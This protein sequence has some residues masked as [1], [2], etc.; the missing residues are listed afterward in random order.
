MKISTWVI[1]TATIAAAATATAQQQPEFVWGGDLR[2][3]VVY[4]DHI[5]YSNVPA[6]SRGGVNSFQR[7]RTR[8]FGEYHPTENF[9]IRSR[10]VNEF[11]TVNHPRTR[12]AWA[13]FDETVID[14]L[15]V[16]YSSDLFDIRL[17]RQD[18]MYGTGKIMLEGTSK[19]GSRTTY[20]DAAKISYKGIEN[21][22][23]D[24]L[25]MYTHGQDPLAIHSQDRDIVGYSGANY[26]GVE[27][28]G[29]IYVKNNSFDDLPWEAY[30]IT[31]TKQDGLP[32]NDTI[33]TVGARFMPKSAGGN[34][35]G[36]IEMAYQTSPGTSEI[37]I[38]ALA[39]LHIDALEAQNGTLGLG[40][41]YL[42]EDWNPVFARWPQ[43]SELYVYSFDTTGA[44]AWK[45][46]SMPHVDFSISP[47]KGLKT[48]LLLGYMMAPEND[49]LGGGHNRGLLFTCKNSFTLKEGLFSESD[50]LSGHLLFEIFEPD[51]YY[52]GSQQDRT[53][54]FAR[55]ELTYSF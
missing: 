17:G 35:D 44:A 29:G 3:R 51:D 16:D 42:S 30:Y 1:M 41:Y 14:N 6:E 11:R 32:S 10:L 22:T 18:L 55:A 19:D 54:S 34:L 25:A 46:V 43:Y 21:T 2:F 24:F 7:Y 28:G 38:D 15:F 9:Y 13:P 49:G 20:F 50:S 36:N 48:D 53:A 52:N 23:I 4:F 45:N 31:K 27:A 33:D 40:W 39:K 5:P 12:N 47:I 8:V 26:D 37:M